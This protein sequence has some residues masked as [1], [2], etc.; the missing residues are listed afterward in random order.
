VADERR[1]TVDLFRSSGSTAER[2][3]AITIFAIATSVIALYTFGKY[4]DGFNRIASSNACA[5]CGE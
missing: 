5:G 4:G 3:A 1:Q 2:F